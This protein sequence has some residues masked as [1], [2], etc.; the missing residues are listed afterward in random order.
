MVIG[1]SAGGAKALP[2]LMPR[3]SLGTPAAITI[4]QQMPSVL[5]GTFAGRA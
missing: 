3:C 2:V 5:T 4:V 1:A